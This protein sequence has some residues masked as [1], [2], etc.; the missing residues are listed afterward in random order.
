VLTDLLGR[1]IVPAL[2]GGEGEPI[3]GPPA[4]PSKLRRQVGKIDSLLS[5]AELDAFVRGLAPPPGAGEGLAQDLV[6]DLVALIL[7]R[8]R[9][10]R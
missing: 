1:V 9:E 5:D 7:N 2:I 6:R 3:F 4:D 8:E 10:E